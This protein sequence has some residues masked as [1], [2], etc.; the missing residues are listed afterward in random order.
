[1]PPNRREF[2]AQFGSIS[3]AALLGMHAPLWAQAVAERTLGSGNRT[4][5]LIELKGGNDGL[6]TVVPYADPNYQALRGNL[7]LKTEELI[8][9]DAKFGLHPELG[10]FLPLWEKGELGIVQ[11]LG[12]P[13]PNLSHF[14]SIEI[15]ETAS[16]AN[17]YLEDGWVTR[18]MRAG[19]AS[20]QAYT[21]EGV[22]IGSSAM[23]P[24]LGARAVTLTNPEA[25]LNQ[26][27]LS[28]ATKIQTQS[29][30][31]P[32][33]QH[34]MQ[35]QDNINHA[36]AGLRADRFNFT[37][38][39]PLGGFGNAVRAACQVVAS[40]KGRSGVPVIALK[41]GSFDTHQNQPGTHANLL[42]QLAE[43]M[44]AIKSAMQELNAWDQTLLMT[45]SEFGRR[46]RPN[47]SNGTDHGTAAPHFVAG[48]AVRGGW[49]GKA[50]DLARL[51]A[52]QNLIYTSDFR[53]LYAGV[54]KNWWGVN[55]EPVVLGNFDPIS[56]L[57]T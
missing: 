42:K 51:D 6:N 22:L 5:I 4:L 37:T 26:A 23:G 18:A 19:L 11:G 50:P 38:V 57:R 33:L 34:L 30:A 43:G 35:V 7:A 46:A 17:E 29:A 55:P 36:A 28:Q 56:F 24:L 12:Y 44:A 32:A 2:L 25:F 53:Q 49:Y 13:Q 16:R 27:R 10:P 14:R 47:N 39:F 9:I 40:Q 1:M 48:G 3:A 21:A 41:L 8:R 54:A 52:T 15:W 20:Q 31:N 45:F